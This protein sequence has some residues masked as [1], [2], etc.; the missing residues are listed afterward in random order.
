VLTAIAYLRARDHEVVVIDMGTEFD[1]APADESAGLDA[2]LLALGRRD[3]RTRLATIGVPV[4][5][6]DPTHPIDTAFAVLQRW[7][8]RSVAGR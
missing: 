5:A 3:A 7:R 6:W 2:R 8:G 1:I 4:A